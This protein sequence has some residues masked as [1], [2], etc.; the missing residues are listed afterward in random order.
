MKTFWPASFA[1]LA[2]FS[3][4]IGPAKIAIAQEASG[5]DQAFSKAN[6]TVG[7]SSTGRPATVVTGPK[8]YTSFPVQLLVISDAS[9]FPTRQI[10]PDAPK[11]TYAKSMISVQGCPIEISTGDMGLREYEKSSAGSFFPKSDAVLANATVDSDVG[12]KIYV[13]VLT[14]LK[15]EVKGDAAAIRNCSQA[16]ARGPVSLGNISLEG[17]R[18]GAKDSDGKLHGFHRR[19]KAPSH[20]GWLMRS[21]DDGTLVVVDDNG[22]TLSIESDVRIF[23]A[24]HDGY[25]DLVVQTGIALSPRNR[26]AK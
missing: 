20:S 18:L 22:L 7:P 6:H 9:D 11:E 21:P 5:I 24:S 2:S 4:M 8:T 14:D 13:S 23:T 1:F 19:G 15:A 16:L 12:G 3:M 25:F 26:A 17:T 10:P